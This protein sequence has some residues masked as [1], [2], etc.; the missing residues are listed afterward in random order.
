MTSAPT[1]SFS[2]NEPGYIVF[3]FFS[4]TSIFSGVPLSTIHPCRPSCGLIFERSEE[5][6]LYFLL[7]PS[8]I[9]PTKVHWSSCIPFCR[10]SNQ[11]SKSSWSIASICRRRISFSAHRIIFLFGRL[12][13]P[14][15]R[16]LCISELFLFFRSQQSQG[17]AI[18]LTGWR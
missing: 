17:L 6:G 3:L 11:E 2:T 12:S 15:Q 10:L 7:R 9:I 13:P 5:V 16:K 4:S 18:G 14:G 1:H 8:L